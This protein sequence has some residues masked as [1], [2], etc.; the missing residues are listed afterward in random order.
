MTKENY[1]MKTHNKK[2]FEF[3]KKNPSLDFEQI[4]ILCVDLFENILQDANNEMN[5]S[6]SSQILLECTEN[7]NK[8]LELNNTLNKLSNDLLI[9]SLDIKRDYIEEVKTIINTNTNNTTD[10]IKSLIE[11]SNEQL[12]DKTYISN[13]NLMNEINIKN[14]KCNSSLLDKTSIIIN[15]IN[16]NSLNKISSLIENS[17]IHLMD[18]TK[19]ILNDI[20]P[21]NQNR[22]NKQLQEDITRFSTLISEDIKKIMNNYE[23]SNENINDILH[24]YQER[25]NNNTL[26]NS[27][28]QEKQDKLF[29]EI[30]TFLNKNKDDNISTFINNFDNKYSSLLQTIQ[31]P[32]LSTINSSE[33]R[34]NTSLLSLNDLS[35]KQHITTNTLSEDFQSYLNK[36]R[37]S[38]LKGQLSENQLNF[39]LTKMFP[40]ANINDTSKITSSGDFIMKRENRDPILI[41][42]KDYNKNVS[43]DEVKKFIIDCDTQKTHGIF[44]SQNTGI[45]SKTNYHIDIHKGHIL[46]YVHNVEFIPEKIQV[47]VDIIDTLSSKIKELYLINNV[48]ENDDNVISKEIMDD[49]NNEYQKLIIQK[50]NL[51]NILNDFQKKMKNQ[52]DEIKIPSLE[53]YLESKYASTTQKGHTC[54]YCESYTTSTIKSLSAHKRAC[55]K[56]PIQNIILTDVIINKTDVVTNKTDVVKTNKKNK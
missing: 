29:I 2:V 19:I 12:L 50:E 14:E 26:S 46:V 18:K 1:E 7:K 52:I 4:N 13:N 10:K 49:I 47:A 45:T 30:S 44:L 40:T 16:S 3:Y 9:K 48:N 41:E 54:E 37:N 38:S 42:N 25:I 31:Q 23:H 8:I 24:K 43:T 56:K 21:E 34:I 11:K 22:S 27:N 33:D 28:L 6:I 53:K 55:P 35:N 5:K 39:V 20:I 17:T 32:I 51:S 36:M 15:E